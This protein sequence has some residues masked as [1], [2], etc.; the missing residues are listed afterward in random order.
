MDRQ[1][2]SFT[3]F[4]HLVETCMKGNCLIYDTSFFYFHF[5]F[6]QVRNTKEKL[7]IFNFMQF[8]TPD[9]QGIQLF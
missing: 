7:F 9:S 4:D 5:H 8:A 2:Y 6:K 3:P 1:Y